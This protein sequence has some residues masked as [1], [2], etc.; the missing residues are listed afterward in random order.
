MHQ[1]LRCLQS[2][3]CLRSFEGD[4]S[5]YC[6]FEGSEIPGE[7]QGVLLAQTLWLLG[8]LLTEAP[9]SSRESK[10]TKR[11]SPYLCPV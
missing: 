2:V 7:W 9:R 4:L 3:C 6:T 1:G 5:A 10:H 8:P 11:A